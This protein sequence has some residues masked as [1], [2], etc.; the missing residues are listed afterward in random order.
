MAYLTYT[1]SEDLERTQK[2]FVK[3]VLKN[4]YKNYEDGLEKLNLDTLANR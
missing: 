4:K 3:M 1:K 2:S